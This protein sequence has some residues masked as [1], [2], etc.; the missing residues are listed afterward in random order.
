[1]KFFFV[2]VWLFLQYMPFPIK[3]FITKM[4]TVYLLWNLSE[5]FKKDS[6]YFIGHFLHWSAQREHDKALFSR[7]PGLQILWQRHSEAFYFDIWQAL[8]LQS[9]VNILGRPYFRQRIPHVAVDAPDWHHVRH[10]WA[11][12]LHREVNPVPTHLFRAEAC[13]MRGV[14]HFF[15][16]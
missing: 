10:K 16:S 12:K 1:M 11:W 4:T 14:P 13:R 15:F 8:R 3:K 2:F 7:H 5:R 9:P 6:G